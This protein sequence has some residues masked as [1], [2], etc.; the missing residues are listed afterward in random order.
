MDKL[1]ILAG[2]ITY[3]EENLQ[4]DIKTEDVAQACYCSKSSLEKIFRCINGISVREYLI[5]R[6]MMLAAKQMLANPGVSVLEVA[7]DCGYSTNESFTR[8]FRS[9]WNCNPSEFREKSHSTELYPKRCLPDKNGG[10][11]MSLSF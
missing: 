10:T 5:R 4:S 11:A 3:I 8:A 1:E 9:I 7:L 6:R 2:A